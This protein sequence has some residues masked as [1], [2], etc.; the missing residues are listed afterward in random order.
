RAL[1]HPD[2]P[3]GTPHLQLAGPANTLPAPTL[4]FTADI[5][6][7]AS[8]DVQLLAPAVPLQEDLSGTVRVNGPLSALQLETTVNAPD[9]QITA[10]TTLNLTQTPPHYEGTPARQ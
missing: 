9:G 6:R 2:L 7:L 10:A 4:A 8:G 5:E 3:P 1:R